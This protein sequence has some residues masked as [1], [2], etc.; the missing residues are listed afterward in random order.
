MSLVKKF[1]AGIDSFFIRSF[2]NI[3]NNNKKIVFLLFHSIVKNEDQLKLNHIDPEWAVTI[4]EFREILDRFLELGYKFITFKDLVGISSYNNYDKNII[5]HFDDGYYNNSNILPIL[6]EYKIN[7]HF[8]L[9]TNNILNGEKFWWD[10]LYNKAKEKGLNFQAE[11]RKINNNNNSSIEKIKLKLLSNF[12][13]NVFKPLSDIDRPFN[14]DEIIDFSKSK[15]VSIGNHTT[16]HSNLENLNSNLVIS[17][18]KNAETF[19]KK[20]IGHSEKTFSFPNS[21]HN[22][23]NFKILR[24]MN[25]E[26]CLSRNYTNLK[27]ESNNTNYSLLERYCFVRS[28]NLNFQINL[29]RSKFSI[30]KFLSKIYNANYGSGGGI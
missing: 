28:K 21:A 16:D 26:H 18:I 1:I 5:I 30:Y 10:A 29:S 9:V 25:F 17:K 27:L 23:S 20:N 19:I 3:I 6:N 4:N 14:T 12:N 15:Y 2:D 24:S 8:F 22:E 13:K 7:S 11:L